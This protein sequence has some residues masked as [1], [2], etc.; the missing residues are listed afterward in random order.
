MTYKIEPISDK[1]F[2]FT[3][4]EEDEQIK[5]VETEKEKVQQTKVDGLFVRHEIVKLGKKKY[6]FKVETS[7]DQHNW[8]PVALDYQNFEK[9]VL[10]VVSKMIAERGEE[11]HEMKSIP[12]SWLGDFIIIRVARAVEGMANL[13]MLSGLCDLEED[14]KDP[15]WEIFHKIEDNFW[16]SHKVSISCYMQDSES[17]ATLELWY[18]DNLEERQKHLDNNSK[19]YDLLKGNAFRVVDTLNP[20]ETT[21]LPYPKRI[22]WSSGLAECFVHRQIADDLQA[23]GA[24]LVSIKQRMHVKKLAPLP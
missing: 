11:K 22:G 13:M 1:V 19:N 9:K 18:T 3:L 24:T 2:T 17:A 23:K 5:P 6:Q 7:L 16:D 10:E 8:K 15:A 12:F 4:F 21:L 20:G 14:W